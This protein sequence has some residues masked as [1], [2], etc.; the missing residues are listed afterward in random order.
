MV[1]LDEIKNYLKIDSDDEDELLLSLIKY[2]REEIL[3]AT[4]D[5]G[6]TPSETYA[7]A[8]KVIIAEAFDLRGND[9]QV[10]SK[11]ILASLFTRL[12]FGRKP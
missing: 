11:G 1:S 3:H 12:K 6:S 7:M 4:G 5:D 9:R 10:D 8:Q 2:S